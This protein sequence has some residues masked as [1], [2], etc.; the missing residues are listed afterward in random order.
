MHSWNSYAPSSW[1]RSTL[2]T[3]IMRVYT[4][5]SNDSYL[6]LELKRLRKVLH[7]RSRYPHWFITKIMDEVKRLNIP[8]EHIQGINENENRV[9]NKQTLILP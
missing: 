4:I 1:K 8:T 5:S 9:T 7:E 2:T 6:K 3:L